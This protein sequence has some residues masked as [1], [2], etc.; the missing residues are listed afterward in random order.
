MQKLRGWLLPFCIS[1]LDKVL[2]TFSLESRTIFTL[3]NAIAF[4][5][6][7]LSKARPM[8]HT[9][10]KP[11]QHHPNFLKWKYRSDLWPSTCMNYTVIS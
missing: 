7:T 6:S 8:C 4:F 11:L 3:E 2:W 1:P 9:P 10:A 5:C